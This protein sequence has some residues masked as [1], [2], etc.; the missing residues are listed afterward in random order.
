MK[1]I[2]LITVDCLRYDHA[3]I[4][5]EK[6][7]NSLGAGI[8]FKNTYATGPATPFSFLGILCSKYPISP[9]EEICIEVDEKEQR[10]VHRPYKNHNRTLLSRVLKNNGYTTYAILNNPYIYG[11]MGYGDGVDYVVDYK[12]IIH[13]EKQKLSAN[14]I[15]KS[16]IVYDIAKGVYCVANKILLKLN[17]DDD[18]KNPLYY[19]AKK[20]TGLAK[21]LLSKHEQGKK[22]YLHLH[23]M[24]AHAPFFSKKSRHIS[25]EEVMRVN[26]MIKKFTLRQTNNA[27]E[28]ELRLYKLMYK[29]G[30]EEIGE[31]VEELVTYLKKTGLLDNTLVVITSDHGELF[32][33]NRAIS[34]FYPINEKDD[35]LRGLSEEILH[36]P[37]A[38]YGLGKGEV[39]KIS[40][41]IDLPPTILDINGIEK[42]PEW[43]GNTLLADKKS[44]VI[45]EIKGMECNCYAIRI[46]GYSLLINESTGTSRVYKIGTNKEVRSS[47]GKQIKRDMLKLLESHKIKKEV[48]WRESLKKSIRKSGLGMNKKIEKPE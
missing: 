32:M 12:G 38:I 19:D 33:E 45:S 41:L 2:I 39:D 9:D 24:D 37:L 30:L 23:Y 3:K 25:K 27:T 14:L 29:H 35:L 6:L 8:V 1:N 16:R 13:K 10:M 26:T 28:E 21:E 48:A 18:I 5:L 31:N 4:I 47:T 17:P 36:V 20:I 11:Q 44:A 15:K 43:Y 40:S 22:F 42:P 7:K 34:H 46:E